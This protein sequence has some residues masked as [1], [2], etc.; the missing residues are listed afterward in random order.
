MVVAAAAAIVVA[1][2]AFDVFDGSHCVDAV[3]IPTVRCCCPEQVFDANDNDSDFVDF[4]A[5][6]KSEK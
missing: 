2:D 4:Q 6:K 1:A 5:C 3:A